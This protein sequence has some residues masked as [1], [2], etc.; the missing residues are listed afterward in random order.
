M[1]PS[2]TQC[3]Q[4]VSIGNVN[5]FRPRPEPQMLSLGHPPESRIHRDAWN[6]CHEKITRLF[7]SGKVD[8][9]WCTDYSR[10]LLDKPKGIRY[11]LRNSWADFQA[12]A[13][14]E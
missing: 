10:V 5:S 11:I 3:L 6:P 8:E 13:E 7:D 2:L 14:R 12:K 1:D 4:R 9:P